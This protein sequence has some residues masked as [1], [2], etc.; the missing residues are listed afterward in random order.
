MAMKNRLKANVTTKS[1]RDH[2]RANISHERN[3]FASNRSTIEKILLIHSFC[4]NNNFAST[5]STANQ[6]NWMRITVLQRHR[7]ENEVLGRVG[8]YPFQVLWSSDNNNAC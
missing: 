3:H 7:I 6:I 8:H 4:A 5:N 2:R 1:T